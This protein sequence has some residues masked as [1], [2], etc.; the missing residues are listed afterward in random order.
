L[1]A[2]FVSSLEGSMMVARATQR[3]GDLETTLNQLIHLISV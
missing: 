1:A 3:P 2:T